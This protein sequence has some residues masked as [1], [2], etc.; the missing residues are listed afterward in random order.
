M[1]KICCPRCGV[2]IKIRP[3]MYNKRGK[4]PQCG[5]RLKVIPQGYLVH[6]IVNSDSQRQ[7]DNANIIPL[8]SDHVDV[9]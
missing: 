6:A 9:S 7:E 8:N 3:R 1:L 2:K 5:Q 4:C